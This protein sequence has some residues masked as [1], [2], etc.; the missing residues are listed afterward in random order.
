[1]S[2]NGEPPKMTCSNVLFCPT[3]SKKSFRKSV[4]DNVNQRNTANLNILI[5][6]PSKYLSFL[7]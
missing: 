6:R 5:V 1:M 4:Y 7:L 3:S 2:G